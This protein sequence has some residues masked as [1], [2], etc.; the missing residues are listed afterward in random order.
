MEKVLRSATR[1]VI[2][3]NARNRAD[4]F[5][6]SSGGLQVGKSRKVAQDSKKLWFHFPAFSSYR[7]RTGGLPKK[8]TGVP[9][10]VREF[11][12]KIT[13]HWCRKC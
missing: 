12:E 3:K 2:L 9:V 7:G 1:T 11:P 10:R 5:I 8:N 4:S 13:V 6:L